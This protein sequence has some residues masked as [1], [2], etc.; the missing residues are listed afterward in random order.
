MGKSQRGCNIS[1]QKAPP[2]HPFSV[3]CKEHKESRE[4]ETASF[5]ACHILEQARGFKYR[6]LPFS[7]NSLPLLPAQRPASLTRKSISGERSHGA[8]FSHSVGLAKA[9]SIGPKSD[10]WLYPG[11]D[12]TACKET[13]INRTAL[14]VPDPA[15]SGHVD[16]FLHCSII[17]RNS[18]PPRAL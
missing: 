9:A 2:L 17:S 4:A 1:P 14:L 12:R 3:L 11:R 16:F 8:H 13:R 15:S 10:L 6:G 18:G 7:S 5:A